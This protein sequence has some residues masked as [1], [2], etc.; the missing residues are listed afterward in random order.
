LTKVLNDIWPL[1]SKSPGKIIKKRIAP[2]KIATGG[3]KAEKIHA[4][5]FFQ[6]FILRFHGEVSLVIF[7][8]IQVATKGKG[9]NITIKAHILTFRHWAAIVPPRFQNK[10]SSQGL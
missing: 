6:I 8:V 3:T 5:Q 4:R 10:I 9:V 2:K 1:K 7:R